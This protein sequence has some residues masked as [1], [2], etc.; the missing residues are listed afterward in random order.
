MKL[1][2]LILSAL[3]LSLPILHAA[4]PIRVACVGDSITQGAGA[5]AGMSYPSQLQTLLG[6]Q[7]KVGNFGVSGRTLMQKGDH[8]YRKEG[9][10]QQALEMLPQMV[11]I[12]LG[13]NDSK[14]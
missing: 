3:L 14:P 8:P 6:E 11:V 1:I 4:D 5:G 12:M 2:P 7:Y 13:T 10:Y 9:K